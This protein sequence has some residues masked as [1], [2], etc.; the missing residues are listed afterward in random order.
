MSAHSPCVFVTFCLNLRQW[1]QPLRRSIICL[2]LSWYDIDFFA[3][4]PASVFTQP[5]P[6][7]FPPTFFSQPLF[8]SLCC[9]P[10]LSVCFYHSVA[11]LG[12]L[13][14]RAVSLP[15]VGDSGVGKSNLLSRFTRDVFCTDEKST[16]G[17][18]FATRVLQMVDG[19][20]IK[21]QIWDTAGQERY[22]AITNAYY[23]G[24]LGAMLVYD[25]TRAE[26]FENIPRWL[27]ELRDHANRDIVLLM[28]GNKTDLC[29]DADDGDVQAGGKRQVSSSCH[30]C[31]S[32][33]SVDQQAI[34]LQTINQSI[35]P[36][37]RNNVSCM[38]GGHGG[39]TSFG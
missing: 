18:E 5:V 17:V 23:R 27:R 1:P 28:V 2:R 31:H 4:R 36:F 21:A 35:H 32:C 10:L 20:K 14:E 37:I 30:F 12:A 19:K 33:V 39:S 6:S 34:H 13:I 26:S 22:R 25:V 9:A 11:Q 38:L 24:A 16:I 7:F 29:G 8:P 3:R 15:Q